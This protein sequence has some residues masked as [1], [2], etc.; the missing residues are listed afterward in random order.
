MLARRM[1]DAGAVGVTCAK[2]S[3]AAAMVDGGVRDVLIANEVA[4]SVGTGVISHQ[5]LLS[6]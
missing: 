1:I 2:V 3:Q 6:S 5:D 4:E